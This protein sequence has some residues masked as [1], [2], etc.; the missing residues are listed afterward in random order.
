MVSSKHSTAPLKRVWTMKGGQWNRRDDI[1]SAR[2]H[3]IARC[4]VAGA[5]AA[6]VEGRFDSRKP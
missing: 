6:Q 3:E 2:P 1:S 5:R 4:E